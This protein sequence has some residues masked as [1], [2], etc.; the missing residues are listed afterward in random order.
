[1]FAYGAWS[2]AWGRADSVFKILRAKD[3]SSAEAKTLAGIEQYSTLT[4]EDKKMM[5]S[6]SYYNMSHDRYSELNDAWNF[7][8][9]SHFYR[10][11]RSLT[12]LGCTKA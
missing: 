2:E 10:N 12:K 7:Y 4:A 9:G 8:G 5:T 3:T 6:S 1:M 11:N